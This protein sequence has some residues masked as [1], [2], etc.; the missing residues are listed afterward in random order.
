MVWM[1]HFHP[2]A[3]KNKSLELLLND[4]FRSAVD[5]YR[6]PLV[7]SGHTHIVDERLQMNTDAS[8]VDQTLYLTVNSAMAVNNNGSNSVFMIDMDLP[9][10][11]GASVAISVRELKW[12]R[13]GY[14]KATS[15]IVRHVQR[16]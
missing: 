3:L 16:S 8:V 4:D 7:L 11:K 9:T 14:Y 6:I 10:A 13:Q 1:I 12:T 2:F 5:Y 15:H